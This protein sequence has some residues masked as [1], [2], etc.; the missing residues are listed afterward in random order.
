MPMHSVA[1]AEKTLFLGQRGVDK[2]LTII[3]L[4][5]PSTSPPKGNVPENHIETATE[6]KTQTASDGKMET[7]SDINM[8]SATDTNMEFAT[9]L[10]MISSQSN[11]F[12]LF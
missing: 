3:D 7:V 9:D 11:I 2:A 4:I 8:G 1:F 10:N 5:L 6:N 12:F